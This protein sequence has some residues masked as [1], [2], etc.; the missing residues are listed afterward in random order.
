MEAMIMPGGEMPF[1]MTFS[2]LS[3][4][5]SQI[6]LGFVGGLMGDNLLPN[7]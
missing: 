6:V 4:I 7:V 1:A 5:F 3:Y 2:R